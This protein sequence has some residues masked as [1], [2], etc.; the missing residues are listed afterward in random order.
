MSPIQDT[1]HIAN[2]YQL[3]NNECFHWDV[4]RSLDT[5]YNISINGMEMDK[6]DKNKKWKS[7]NKR[8]KKLNQNSNNKN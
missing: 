1:L 2:N 7:I 3:I 8:L 4:T 6:R 5:I